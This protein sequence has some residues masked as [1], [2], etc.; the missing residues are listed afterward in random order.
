MPR[1]SLQKF[2]LMCSLKIMNF[3]TYSKTF[4][5]LK[6]FEKAKQKNVQT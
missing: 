4:K 5:K 6:K 1:K 2:K 3:K